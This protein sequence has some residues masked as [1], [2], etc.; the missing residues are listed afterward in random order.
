[1]VPCY[2]ALMAT[3]ASKSGTFKSFSMNRFF[4]DSFF[5]C[6]KFIR[7][8]ELFACTFPF[9]NWLTKVLLNFL[10]EPIKFVGS[11]LH[12]RCTISPR[13]WGN[14]LHLMPSL[15]GYIN[16][17]WRKSSHDL[18]FVR[19]L[20]SGHLELSRCE[21]KLSVSWRKRLNHQDL[22]GSEIN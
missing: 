20:N 10:K 11:W 22:L 1:M 16:S 12:Q 14:A 15:A 18:W 4:K 13:V 3:F 7:D 17:N 5:P 19:C 9:M 8:I 6:F 2:K 21:F